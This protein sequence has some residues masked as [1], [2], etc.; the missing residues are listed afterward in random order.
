MAVFARPGTFD[1]ANFDLAIGELRVKPRTHM[2]VISDQC[3]WLTTTT[4]S[5]RLI[6]AN[7]IIE[8]YKTAFLHL[9][10]LSYYYVCNKT[11]CS[12]IQSIMSFLCNWCALFRLSLVKRMTWTIDCNCL[13]LKT[14]FLVKIRSAHFPMV[15]VNANRFRLFSS[16]AQS[17]QVT[18]V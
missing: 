17:D 2:I 3:T 9:F 10:P 16:S 11:N 14:K 12:Y 13:K 8:Q 1:L 18:S 15:Y 5:S 7:W 4:S 6:F